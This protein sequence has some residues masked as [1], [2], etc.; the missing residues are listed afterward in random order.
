MINHLIIFYVCFI[1]SRWGNEVEIVGQ[2]L[3][4][5]NVHLV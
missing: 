3:K 5:V 1:I 2:L 4:D